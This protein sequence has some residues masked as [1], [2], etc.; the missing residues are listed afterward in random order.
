MVGVEDKNRMF[1]Q[2][3]VEM[4]RRDHHHQSQ[5]NQI[6]SINVPMGKKKRLKYISAATKERC[7]GTVHTFVV[8]NHS[9]RVF[10]FFL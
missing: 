10:F 6:M 8:Q 5:S 1:G 7:N 9:P 3:H 4:S 2:T